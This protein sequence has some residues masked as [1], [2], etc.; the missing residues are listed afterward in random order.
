[1]PA[2][3]NCFSYSCLPDEKATE[4]R[5]IAATLEPLLKQLHPTAVEAGRELR[6]AKALVKHGDFGPFC[7]DVMKAD[8]RMC[9]YYICIADIADEIGLE[10]VEQMP[11]SSAAALSSAPAEVVSQIVAEMKDGGKCPSVRTIKERSR[12]ARGNGES[13]VLVE[14]DDQRV[15]NVASI[16]AT[17]LDTQ[18][19]ADLMELLTNSASIVALCDKIRS[20]I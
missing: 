10:L 19:L 9:Q 14:H 8:V 16:L 6:K 5:N 4:L 12:E 3:N 7:R 20:L 15:A 11:P 2:K 18:E 17:K 13:V 1:M